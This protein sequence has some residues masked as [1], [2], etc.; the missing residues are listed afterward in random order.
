MPLI[1]TLPEDPK[2]ITNFNDGLIWAVEQT[3]NSLVHVMIIPGFNIRI[4]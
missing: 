3:R 4:V 2:G 1:E